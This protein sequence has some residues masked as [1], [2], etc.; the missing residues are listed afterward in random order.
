MLLLHSLSAS[1]GDQ[2]VHLVSRK[3]LNHGG[4]VATIIG[5]PLTILLAWGAQTNAGS[6]TVN[7]NSTNQKGGITANTV[8]INAPAVPTPSIQPQLD[9]DHLAII[10]KQHS[11]VLQEYQ[12]F[13][14]RC[15]TYGP[16][17]Q[18]VCRQVRN[19]LET[20][21]AYFNKLCK[22][23]KVPRGQYGCP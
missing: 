11:D 8:N 17:F 4:V 21:T 6:E 9:P 10:L 15:K 20:Q 18:D 3:K 13:N 12:I 1:W 14:T 2:N 5:L 7:V 16:E 22:D 19:S 23:N